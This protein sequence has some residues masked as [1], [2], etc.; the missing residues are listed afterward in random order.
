MMQMFVNPKVF[1]LFSS[2]V[3]DL[4]FIWNITLLLLYEKGRRTAQRPTSFILYKLQGVPNENCKIHTFL[5]LFCKITLKKDCLYQKFHALSN[6]NL[7][8][9]D[10]GKLKLDK[11]WNTRKTR[12]QGLILRLYSVLSFIYNFLHIHRVTI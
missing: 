8:I 2:F 5:T 1:C 12:H 10:L 4:N 7:M 11:T 9:C 6:S 3:R